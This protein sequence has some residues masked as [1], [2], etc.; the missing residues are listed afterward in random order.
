MKP[1]N[2][3]IYYAGLV[4]ATALLAA[5]CSGDPVDGPGGQGGFINLTAG[6]DATLIDASRAIEGMVTVSDLTITLRSADGKVDKTFNSIDDFDVKTRYA[7]GAYTMQAT[8]GDPA[9]EGFESP[10]YFGTASFT[11]LESRTTDVTLTAS[12]ANAMVSVTATDAFKETF[13]NFTTTVHSNGGVYTDV[14]AYETRPVYVKPG[15]VTLTGNVTVSGK[16]LTLA[17]GE[18]T[19]KA[20]TH[21]HVTLDAAGSSGSLELAVKF[22]DSTQFED[23]TIT[24]SDEMINAPAPTLTLRGADDSATVNAVEG[25]RPADDVRFDVVAH[26]GLRSLTL[27]TTN[28]P[29]LLAAGWP[30]EVD[31]AAASA[32]KTLMEGMGLRTPGTAASGSTYASVVLTDVISAIADN[33]ATFTL[34]ANDRYGKASAPHS[35]SI[36]LIPLTMTLSGNQQIDYGDKTVT[37]TFDYNGDKVSDITFEMCEGESGQWKTIAPVSV[38]RKAD[39]RYEVVLPITPSAADLRFRAVKGTVTSAI[40][41]V[42]RDVPTFV[43]TVN[44]GDVWATSA[45]VSLDIDGFSDAVTLFY[46]TDGGKNYS[47]LAVKADSDGKF[48]LASLTPATTYSVKA[49]MGYA[50]TAA[51]KA[52][53]FTTEAATGVPNGDFET[54]AQTL[55]LEL[56]QGGTWTITAGGT[57]RTTTASITVNEPTGWAST[58]AK[59]AWSGSS[60]VNT[61]YVVPSVYNTT[62]SWVTHQPTAKVGFIGQTGYD[63]TPDVYSNLSAASGSNAMVIRNVAWDSNGAAIANDSKTG[64]TDYSN[65]YC[66]KQPSISRR[67]AGMLFLGSYSYDGTKETMNQGVDFGSRPL[68]L[69]GQFKYVRDAGDANENGVVTIELLAG[70]N[71]IGSA[72]LELPATDSFTTF[73]L[74]VKYAIKDKKA[75]SLRILFSSSNRAESAIKTTNYCNK[76]ECVSRG[77]ALTIDNLKFTY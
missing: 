17:L 45:I 71:V 63:A 53:T 77:A 67:S 58:N 62:L 2:H 60:N 76:L 19:A 68:A 37:L 57:K 56:T 25:C 66:S 23:I 15:T 72:S 13:G 61:W 59:T 9:S 33:G 65:Y 42:T 29:S 3:I 39:G 21:Y 43:P 75:T 55:K 27:T 20:K 7:A 40:V 36:G 48:T 12:L 22:D 47:P 18:F 16:E 49:T 26:A 30:A 34:V 10:Y 69:T 46:S 6:I 1:I 73:T 5:G 4:G 64:N 38:T 70:N 8:F 35:V 44:P 51:D 41:T 28:A 74:P 14:A 52:A 32:E 31:L 54:L 24:L 11:V 50:P